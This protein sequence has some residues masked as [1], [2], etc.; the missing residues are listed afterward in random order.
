[1]INKI[2]V[3]LKQIN[4]KTEHVWKIITNSEVVF[5]FYN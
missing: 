2:P 4:Y 1:M 3:H 5:T